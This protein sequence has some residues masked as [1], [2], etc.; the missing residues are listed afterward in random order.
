MTVQDSIDSYIANL[1]ATIRTTNGY[2]TSA[3]ASVYRE[4][5]YTEYPDVMPCI[6]W[7]PG[8]L[9]SGVEVGPV[10]PD[11][12]QVNHMYPM[13]WEGFIADDLTGAAG[14]KLKA[15]LVKALYAD[16]RFGG[17]IEIIDSCKSSVA[18]QA[19]DEIYSIVQVAFTIFY[20]TPF[21]QE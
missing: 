10:P 20:V 3:G 19:G 17:L 21:G 6:A 5:A 1:L 11:M 18:V 13:S 7:F 12:G 4:L 9:Q 15:D 16:L 14:R 8:E 2:Q